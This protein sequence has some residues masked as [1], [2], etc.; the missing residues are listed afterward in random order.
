MEYRIVTGQSVSNLE[1]AVNVAIKD[2]WKPQGGLI[3]HGY[4][5]AQA[6]VKDSKADIERSWQGQVDRQGG[7]F[8]NEE[9][10][11]GPEWGWR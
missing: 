5:Y 7:S 6:L 11:S 9:I 3:I 4:D 10:M 8:S 1:K 2:G